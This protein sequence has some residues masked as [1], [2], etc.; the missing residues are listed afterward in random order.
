MSTRQIGLAGAVVLATML[1]T[2]AAPAAMGQ[3]GSATDELRALVPA[4]LRG[5]CQRLPVRDM[6]VPARG[7][8]AALVCY[9]EGRVEGVGLY[10]VD[11]TERL[12]RL[13]QRLPVER[14]VFPRRMGR[15]C[16]VSCGT[17]L[18]GWDGRWPQAQAQPSAPWPPGRQAY[19]LATPPTDRDNAVADVTPVVLLSADGQEWCRTE[20]D[21]LRRSGVVG[22]SVAPDSTIL[23]A[24]YRKW[25]WG[26]PVIWT[27]E[28][29]GDP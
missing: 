20:P 21:E 28:P 29:A 13:T 2:T 26:G 19:A 12:E 25:P 8:V 7:S 15:S 16:V 27:R 22:A 9:P 10:L 6:A 11:D 24:G 1:L 4:A 23:A 17:P 5:T 14:G 18:L 3:D